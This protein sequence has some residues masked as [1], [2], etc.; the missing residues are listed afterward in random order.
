MTSICIIHPCNPLNKFIHD[1][2]NGQFITNSRSLH[3]LCYLLPIHH[4]VTLQYHNQAESESCALTSRFSGEKGWKI[5][6]FKSGGIPL[7]LSETWICIFPNNNFVLTL[8]HGFI[9]ISMHL[10]LFIDCISASF[11][12]GIESIVEQIE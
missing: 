4:H 1:S 3:L 10:V 8:D 12:T 9:I 6:S 11:S 7:P 5:L 2:D